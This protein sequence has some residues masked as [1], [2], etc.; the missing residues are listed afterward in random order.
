M[1][2]KTR[3]EASIQE[4]LDAYMEIVKTLYENPET[5]F[6]EYETQKVLVKYLKDAG[7]DRYRFC[8]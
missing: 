6:Q 2:Y 8:G 3:I 5:G 7:C 1:D 4:H